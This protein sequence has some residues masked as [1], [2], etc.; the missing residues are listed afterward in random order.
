[1]SVNATIKVIK[2]KEEEEVE[3]EDLLRNLTT[4]M[5]RF[6]IVSI[7]NSSDNGISP[8]GISARRLRAEGSTMPACPEGLVSV[9]VEDG[10]LLLRCTR[11]DV[12]M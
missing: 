8:L 1:M 11:V 12:K 7:V 3:V 2:V 10:A 6:Y 5:L 9:D 4:Q